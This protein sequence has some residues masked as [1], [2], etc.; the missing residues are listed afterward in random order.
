MVGYK[1]DAD[2]LYFCIPAETQYEIGGMLVEDE[3]YRRANPTDAAM[4]FLMYLPCGIR[5]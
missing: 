3:D 1:G 5:L 2:G 4:Y